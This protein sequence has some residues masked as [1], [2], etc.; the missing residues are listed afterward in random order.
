MITA[1]L[2]PLAEL[3]A[4]RQGSVNP[5]QFQSETFELFS[6]PAFDKRKPEIVS[7]AEIGSAKVPVEPGDV[8]LSRIV[9]HIRRAWVVPKANSHRQIASGEWIVFRGKE[10][11]PGYLRHLLT[12]DVFHVQFMNTVAGVGGSLMRARPAFVGKIEIPLPPLSEQRRI[13]D[14]LDKAD[15]IRRKRREAAR[16]STRLT[17]ST[18]LQ[19]FGDPVNNPLGWKRVPLSKAA[20]RVT[21]G[22][23]VKPAS[24]YVPSGVPALRSLNVR[25]NRIAHEKFVYFSKSDNETRLAKT[26]LWKGDVVM[27]RSGQPGT[28]AVVPQELNGVN[29]IDLLIV[30]PSEGKLAPQYL[31]YFMNSPAGRR[32]ALG[33]QRGQIQKHL[34][35]G[36]LNALALPLPPYPLQERFERFVAK[37]NDRARATSA[38][39]KS[40]Q[41]LFE[42]LAQRAFRGEL[43]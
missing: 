33:Q 4:K 16:L 26:R 30:T 32:L 2:I 22:I 36:S 20:D 21:V 14:I 29:A 13:A 3:M 24:Y 5:S 12:S 40:S 37:S 11:V 42:S 27:V 28:A 34:N 17:Q 8:L 41:E 25:E 1:A 39:D 10:F 6:I 35:V 15:A 7:G 18:F 9:P 19:L 31:A 23:V 43:S 38:S